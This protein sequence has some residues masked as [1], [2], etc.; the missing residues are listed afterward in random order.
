[1]R[2]K[3]IAVLA[4]RLEQQGKDA[5]IE[6]LE[7]ALERIVTWAD[8]YPT[9]VFPEPDFKAVRRALKEAGLSLDQ[10][11]ASSMRHVVTGVGEIARSALGKA[12]DHG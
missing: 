12:V 6:V 9:D 11:S 4:D 10:V 2:A 5:R 3:D 8:A 1:M 7:E